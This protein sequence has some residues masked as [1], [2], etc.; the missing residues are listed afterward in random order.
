MKSQQSNIDRK[1][2]ETF[3]ALC[4]KYNFMFFFNSKD[5]YLYIESRYD[6]WRIS[7]VAA[8]CPLLFHANRVGNK[9]WLSR[10][11]KMYHQQACAYPSILGYVGY[12]HSHD[13]Y[14]CNQIQKRRVENQRIKSMAFQYYQ[15]SNKP[16]HKKKLKKFKKRKLLGL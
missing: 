9:A 3:S 2:M 10:E 13:N 4:K 16:R 14:R 6:T 5:G 7:F 11:E 15:Q 1:E 8:G 12:I